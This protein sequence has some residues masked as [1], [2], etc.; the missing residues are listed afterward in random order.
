MKRKHVT[1]FLVRPKRHIDYI[2][3]IS[4]FDIPQGSAV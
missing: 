1:L 3:R 4:M 2:I